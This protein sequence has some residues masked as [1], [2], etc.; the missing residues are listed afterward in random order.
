MRRKVCMI[1]FAPDSR[2]QAP[3]DD[4][5][6]DVWALNE[7]YV[8]MP[9]LRSR[10]DAWF[11][12]HGTEPPTV[13]DPQ[14]A[15]QLG[16]IKCPV[17]M[18]EEHREIPNSTQYPLD[19]ILDHFDIYGEGMAPEVT[20]QRDRNY[21]TNSISWMIALAIFKGYEEIHL[22]GV[23]MAQDQ[24]YQHQR[25][26]CEMF[27]GWA[28]GA[29][30]KVNLPIQ[31]DLCRSFML[32]GYDDGSAY[33]QKIYS[34]L[35]EL[36]ERIAQTGAQRQQLQSQ[37]DSAR[38]AEHQLAGAREDCLYMLH[39][40]VPHASIPKVEV[41]KPDAIPSDPRGSQDPTQD[42]RPG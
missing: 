26:S 5:S 30:I 11:Q 33:H 31:S 29:G 4:N 15:K 35:G 3:L 39:M 40:G 8:E 14:Q 12:L 2:E 19:L 6:M 25:P 10:A 13:R 38:N 41:K 16:E 22:Y 37:A 42:V 17:Y 9:R 28:R 34:R 21:F 24:E 1:G 32:Y 36:E 20:Q 7:L 23:N 27:V 18:W